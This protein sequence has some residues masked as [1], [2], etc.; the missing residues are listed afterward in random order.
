MKYIDFNQWD[1]LKN[2]LDWYNM[3]FIEGKTIDYY[4]NKYPI[5]TKV[6]LR[7]DSIFY[8]KNTNNDPKYTIG[9]IDHYY[10]D[11]IYNNLSVIK[12]NYFIFYVKWLNGYINSYRLIDLEYYI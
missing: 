8:N 3:D 4:K 1:K 6:K 5:G 2:D 11:N 9:K 12:Y 10:N 7:K